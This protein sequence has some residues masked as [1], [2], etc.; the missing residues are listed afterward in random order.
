MGARSPKVR[1]TEHR[2]PVYQLYGEREHWPTP[3]LVHCE[4]IAERSQLHD[5]EI[6]IHQHHALFQ[7]LFLKSGT[8]RVVLDEHE[9]IMQSGQL[10]LVPQMC[11][12]GFRF[13]PD[14]QGHVITMAHP[15]V[16]TLL[17]GLDRVESFI[18]L[19][20]IFSLDAS[21]SFIASAL[22]LLHTE[23][24]GVAPHRDR[25]MT[26]LLQCVFVWVGR[27]MSAAQTAL[28]RPEERGRAFFRQFAALIETHYAHGW[29][30]ERYARKIG[31]TATYLNILCREA[32]GQS[33]LALIHQRL[34][35]AA[36]RELVYTTMTISVVAETLGFTDP[37]YFTRFFRR[38]VG[39]SPREFRSQAATLME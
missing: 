2:I 6:K 8:A 5:W 12:H 36:K 9:H 22:E 39:V 18:L 7:L 13:D 14:A 23:Y 1:T 38:H 17:A 28:S 32:T 21:D 26:S 20:Q 19:P 31:I 34:I 4:L 30:I 11:I 24:R 16:D 37:A 3:D 27:Q 29:S 35:L 25:L 15:L 10:V 33:A